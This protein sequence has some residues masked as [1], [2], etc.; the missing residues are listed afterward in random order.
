MPACLWAAVLCPGLSAGAPADV[1]VPLTSTVQGDAADAGAVVA[2]EAPGP[3]STP[4][5]AGEEPGPEPAAGGGAEEG[6]PVAPEA[7]VAIGSNQMVSVSWL[8]SPAENVLGYNVYRSSEEGTYG[9]VPVNRSLVTGTEF[10]DN[11]ENSTSP[12]ENGVLYFYTVKAVDEE[13]R[14]SEVSEEARARPEGAPVISEIP[15][16]GWEGFGESQLS[17]TGQKVVSLGYTWKIPK[18]GVGGSSALA[19][20]KQQRPELEQQLRV[21]LQ[22]TVGKKISVDVD[23]D[24][25]APD[26]TRQRISVVYA[27]DAQETIERAEFGDIRLKLSETEFTGYDKQLFGVRLQARPLEKVRLTGIATQTQGINASEH[28]EGGS[29]EQKRQIAD[30]AYVS[31]KYFHISNPNTVAAR[32]GIKP[33]SERIWVDDGNAS[34]NVSGMTRSISVYNF[35]LMR[36]GV[37]Y[38]L[39]YDTGTIMFSR[40]I[41]YTYAIAAEFEYGDG[42]RVYFNDDAVN[43]A[44]DLEPYDANNDAIPDR[45]K[46]R[47]DITATGWAETD[48][49]HHLIFDGQ[50][51]GLGDAHMITNIYQLGH[52]NVVP[53]EFD[54]KFSIQVYDS[55]NQVYYHI[56]EPVLNSDFYDFGILKMQDYRGPLPGGTCRMPAGPEC[57]VA[58][59]PGSCPCPGDPGRYYPP[60]SEQPFAYSYDGA[61]FGIGK[62]AYRYGRGEMMSR[63]AIKYRVLTRVYTYNLKNINIVRGS[64]R[65][66]LDGR[67]LS[68]EVDYVIDYD[69][70]NIQF[71]RQEQIRPNS[72]IQIDY[73]YLPFGG[74]FQS[75]LW[76]ARAEYMMSDKSALGVTYLANNAQN[77]Q[78]A[79]APSG[80][81]RS[82]ELMGADVRTFLSRSDISSAVKVFPGF[83]HTVV[84]LEMEVRGE[85]ARSKINPNTFDMPGSGEQGAGMID[86]MEGAD[87]VVA[88]GVDASAWFPASRPVVQGYTMN[89]RAEALA[90]HTGQ[91][92]VYGQ[93]VHTLDLKYQGFAAGDWDSLRYVLS[94]VTLDFSHHQFLEIRMYGDGTGNYLVVDVGSISED[95]NGDGRLSTEDRNGDFALNPG[96]DVGINQNGSAYWGAGSASFVS[97]PAWPGPGGEVLNTE[98]MN[99]NGVLDETERCFQYRIPMTWT[100]WM[101]VK[102]PLGFDA[103][104]VQ[105]RTFDANVNV[106]LTPLESGAG[107]GSVTVQR[108]LVNAELNAGQSDDR[109]VIRHMRLSLLGAGSASAG[110][111]R[112]ESIEVTGNRW[113]LSTDPGSSVLTDSSRFTVSVINQENAGASGY[114]PLLTYY[115]V[116]EAG[117]ERMEQAL[118]IEY[119]L[120]DDLGGNYLATR[121]FPTAINMLDYGE[122]RLDV[123]KANV[124]SSGEFLFI[125][126][127]GDERNYFQYNV[128]LDHVGLGWQTVVIDVTDERN[129]RRVGVPA[130]SAI[131]QFSIGVLR[132]NPPLVD[133]TETLWINNLRLVNPKDKTGL[134]RKVNVRL[135]TPMG[136]TFLLDPAEEIQPASAGVILDT[137]YKDIDND[138]RLIDQPLEMRNDQHSRSV[139][140]VAQI[141]QIPKLPITANFSRNEA[142]VEPHHRDDP[143]YF[144]A[145]D[146]ETNAYDVRVT[147]QHLNPI[148]LNL[149]T[150]RNEENVA[151]LTGMAGSDFNRV[152]WAAEPG[153]RMPLEGSFLYVPLGRGGEVSAGGRYRKERV[154]YAPS[155]TFRNLM[156]RSTE[157]IDEKYEARTTY[158][159]L[160]WLGGV[161]PLVGG[162]STSPRVGYGLSRSRGTVASLQAVG[163]QQ[164]GG[165]TS[166]E[167]F[168]PV[169][170]DMS[171]SLDNRLESMKGMTP[172]VSYLA[173][174]NRNYSLQNL[175]TKSALTNSMDLRPGDWVSALRGYSFNFSYTIDTSAQYYDEVRTVNYERVT[176][177]PVTRRVPLREIWWVTR[178]DDELTASNEFANSYNAS[179][180]LSFFQTL[181]FGPNWS[182]REQTSLRQRLRDRRTT[183]RAGSSL[184]LDRGELVTKAFRYTPLFWMHLS[185][186]TTSYNF[187]KSIQYDVRDAPAAQSEG[188]QA[189]AST[190]FTPLKNVHGTIQV[191]A[192]TSRAWEAQRGIVTYQRNLQPSVGLGY[193]R[194]AGLEIPLIW[195]RL[196]LANLFTIRHN[197]HMNFID[198]EVVVPNVDPVSGRENPGTRRARELSDVTE[199]EYEMMRGVNLRMRAQYDQVWDFTREG[200]NWKAFMFLGTFTFS[201]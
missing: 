107:A 93:Q 161:V 94:P 43:G 106:S 160:G 120:Y 18:E 122:L 79:P 5:G 45:L 70:G 170:Q 201:F 22:G 180:R 182:F 21:R 85:I 97:Y 186:F 100:G 38:S 7:V 156:D 39:D 26:R 119:S 77:P 199:F 125:R 102:I 121:V 126:A 1:S 174:A 30:T 53:P 48:R 29:E 168:Q 28:F 128:S 184:S 72:K 169:T 150:T 189:N 51:L 108:R 50:R 138:F 132:L 162:L 75:F 145:P 87:D 42:T 86:G 176:V 55:N 116:R 147:S 152:N 91:R 159:P 80:A 90:W 12:P 78:D 155:A 14:L 23:Y 164:V 82:T 163:Y 141:R 34:N 197:F 32:L 31:M 131:K 137:T 179:G 33:G 191:Q 8:P 181:T 6:R 183:T 109:S 148:S 19:G 173:N 187:T 105:T 178:K 146:R 83:E 118:R 151:Y 47:W 136:A 96:E 124:V 25:T 37:D 52:R 40:A 130:L 69:F 171:M 65:I 196:K 98:D 71:L 123:Y 190:N 17:V 36:Q 193:T 2:D 20:S 3:E 127:G 27:G 4:A 111:V 54:D 143:L 24:D 63:Y 35:D 192:N 175:N 157:T 104:T 144:F 195:W 115:P 10:L 9:T 67:L 41:G 101:L 74:Q 11:E 95:S 81:P 64:E 133:V 154:D 135:S 99:G 113:L 103:R 165:F 16:V 129:R 68:R 84:P 15:R 198:N 158:R 73:E 167:R 88:V 60:A 114:Q 117:G 139:Q 59:A 194:A 166:E 112:I 188:H 134:A 140:S 49:F 56:A 66:T 177:D 185:G 58:P 153:A 57:P 61:F 62:N 46:S 200:Q 110:S 142:Y 76:G 13:G 44:P 92:S 149:V 89:L 172:S